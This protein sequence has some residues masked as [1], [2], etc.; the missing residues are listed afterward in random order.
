MQKL[1]KFWVTPSF[2]AAQPS[3]CCLRDHYHPSHKDFW[4]SGVQDYKSKWYRDTHTSTNYSLLFPR[5]SFYWIFW[6]RNAKTEVSFLSFRSCRALKTEAHSSCPS[7]RQWTNTNWPTSCTQTSANFLRC[8]WFAEYSRK[9]MSYLSFAF[10]CTWSQ[11][12]NGEP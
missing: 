7:H 6:P 2:C 9:L 10:G 5:T 1:G 12:C 8:S 4:V 3:Y 11:P